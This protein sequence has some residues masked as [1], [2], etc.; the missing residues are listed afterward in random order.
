MQ[1]LLSGL[2]FWLAI[3]PS[4]LADT[5]HIQ[6]TKSEL[7]RRIREAKG[8][9][10]KLLQLCGVVS[11]DRAKTLRTQVS[12]LLRETVPPHDNVHQLAKILPSVLRNPQEVQDVFGS[13]KMVNRQILYR[14]YLEQWT[15]Q[16]PVRLIL[17]FECQKGEEPVL[18]QAWV[19]PR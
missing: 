18:R 7:D 4:V 16:R 3:S 17:V 15:Y 11:P 2:I 13:E 10:M 1:F 12:R 14:R 9:P 8:D 6:L 19:A 5:P